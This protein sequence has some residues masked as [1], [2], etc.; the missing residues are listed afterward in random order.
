MSFYD[1]PLPQ[2]SVKKRLVVKYFSAWVRVMNSIKKNDKIAYID[3]F[4][5]PGRYE[6]G[7]ISTPLEILNIIA[8]NNDYCNKFVT[9]FNDKDLN[10]VSK[11]K[12][13]IESILAIHKLKH[14]PILMNEEIDINFSDIFKGAMIPSLIFIDPWGYKGITKKLFYELLKSWGCDCILFFNYN[15][16]RPGIENPK[17]EEHMVSLFG[18]DR[19]TSLNKKL[20][21]CQSGDCEA[22]IL[23]EF[24]EA[25]RDIGAKYVLPFRFENKDQDKTSHYIIFLSKNFLGYNIMKQ[26]M[27]NE[28]SDKTQDVA[29]FEYIPAKNQQLSL[30]SLFDRPLDELGNDLLKK[31]SKK[32]LTLTELYQQHSID[33]K[34]IIKNYKDLLIELES[35]SKIKCEPSIKER[36]KGTFADT[37]RIYFP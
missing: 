22:I 18:T 7:T 36:R 12:K 6:D 35:Q 13:E 15:R 5:G 24:A 4:C 30:L 32:N 23:N 11:L 34:F 14:K 16:I 2:S 19:F 10:N 33:T 17:M 8:E 21:T 1:E 29:S 31:Y 26:I 25:M 27:Y 9:V 37:T 28:S 20:K 3:L